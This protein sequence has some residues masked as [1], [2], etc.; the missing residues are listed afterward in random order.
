MKPIF[1]SLFIALS[2]LASNAQAH[3][4]LSNPVYLLNA[5]LD[6]NSEQEMRKV[7]EH[8][9]FDELIQDDGFISYYYTDGTI[10]SFKVNNIS[11][12]KVIPLINVYSKH[13]KK[14]I[15][16]VLLNLGFEKTDKDFTKGS[17][18]T[19]S[20]VVCSFTSPHSISCT[21]HYNR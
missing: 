2:A 15:E 9:N 7:L 13:K 5:L 10:I 16:K 4:N 3:H 1:L 20:Q 19:Q 8:Y 21:R 11:N 17:K 18:H 6:C 12:R 14:D